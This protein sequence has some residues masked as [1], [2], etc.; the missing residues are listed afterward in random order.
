MKKSS[1]KKQSRC[2]ERDLTVKSTGNFGATNRTL[3]NK[4]NDLLAVVL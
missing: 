4:I 1:I 2:N 3:L